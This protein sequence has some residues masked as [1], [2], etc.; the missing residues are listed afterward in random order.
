MPTLITRKLAILKGEMFM[1]RPLLKVFIGVIFISLCLTF[2]V[3]YT[4]S[5][6]PT[7]TIDLTGSK[8]FWRASLNIHLQYDGELIIMP[9]RNDFEI[10]SEIS[11]DIIVNNKCVYTNTLKYIPDSNKNLLGRYMA[12]IDSDDIISGDYFKRSNDEVYIN[13]RSNGESSS[14]LL[15]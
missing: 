12:R 1:K 5:A 7:G 8:D 10:P 3:S 4:T 13:I 9:I 2:Y 15:K 14:I 6:K 11:T